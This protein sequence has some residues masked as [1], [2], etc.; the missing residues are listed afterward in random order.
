M[1]V[2]SRKIITLILLVIT[3]AGCSAGKNN[4]VSETGY[5]LGTIVK[6]TVYDDV[7]ED[8][9]TKSFNIIQSY[10]NMLSR[11]IPDSE[12]SGINSMAGIGEVKVSEDTYSLLEKGIAYSV[13]SDGRFDISVGPLVSLW[14]IGT[15]NARVPGNEE[16]SN[17]LQ[18]TGYKKIKLNSRNRSAELPEKGM[19]I[20]CG[21]VAKGF[22]AD[23]VSDFLKEEGIKSAIINLGGNILTIG[24]KPDKS[25][26]R[27]GIQDPSDTRGEYI[28]IAEINGKSL[29][30]SGIYERYFEADGIRYHHILDSETGYPVNNNVQSI[31]VLTD[32]SA[33][34]DALSTALFSMGIKDGLLFAESY[35][36]LEI[37]YISKENKIFMTDGFSKIFT[38][39][40]SNYSI[41]SE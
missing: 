14:G 27:I 16:I 26:F 11:N 40:N 4:P 23:R 1:S 13:L 36:N 35:E 31:S 30:T 6:I 7:S 10:E 38:L 9:F 41:A 20:D 37:L 39:R 34:G 17:A 21:A 32:L 28:G 25:P 29:V 22:I 3:L 24:T 18:L 19:E 15:D 5:F 2:L 8:I 12:I 33:D